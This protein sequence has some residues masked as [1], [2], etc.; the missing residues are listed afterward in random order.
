M[1]V[2]FLTSVAQANPV[3]VGVDPPT[4]GR[5]SAD[6]ESKLLNSLHE[7]GVRVIRAWI[8]DDTSYDFVKKDYVL[9]IKA[10]LTVSLVSA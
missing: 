4:V 9:G 2:C 6:E 5:L 7:S 10:E 8:A 3:V 1:L